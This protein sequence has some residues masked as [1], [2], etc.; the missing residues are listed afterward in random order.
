[1]KRI[2][3]L[4]MA[5]LMLFGTVAALAGCSAPKDNGAQ[6]EI[7]LGNEVCDFDPSD[8]YADSTAEQVM[9]LLY[10]PLFSLDE[11]GKLGLAAA[12]NYEIDYE[13]REIVVELR[14]SYWSDEVRVTAADFIYAWNERLLN[15]TNP[16][17]AAALLYEIENAVSVKSGEGTVSDV[18]ARATGVYEIT[19]TY[20]DGGDPNLLLHNLASVATSPVRQDKASNAPSYWSKMLDTMV[21]NGPFKVKVFDTATS[22]FTLERNRGYHLSL[23]AKNF[24]KRVTPGV[25]Y[26]FFTP[27]GQ[28]ISVTADEIENKTKFFMC[29]ATLADRASAK[30]KAIV[31][32]T[33]SAYT[34]IFNPENPLFAIPEVRQ[35]LIMAIDREA[36]A[37]AITFAKAANGVLPDVCGGSDSDLIS[38]TAKID[39][40]KAL[41]SNVSFAGVSKSFS[42]THANTELEIKIAEMVCEAWKELGFNVT[43]RPV[44]NTKNKVGD[45]EFYDSRIQMLL[46]EASFGNYGYDVLGFDWQFYS[47]DAFTGLSAFSGAMNGCGYDFATGTAR[48]NVAGYSNIE[49]DSLIV[50]AMKLRGEERAEVLAEAE[51]MLVDNAAVCPI[52]FNQSFAIVSKDL[53]NVKLDA[54]GHFILTEAD[55]KNYEKYIGN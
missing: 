16:N 30:D 12:K 35:A 25:L 17:P 28:E 29:E 15:P 36:I 1:M 8:Y 27:F 18:G 53:R 41:L 32:D 6:F 45:S 10:E 9:S 24:A 7:Y 51:K 2:F 23:D 38:T 43:A 20:R 4:I 13:K 50:E 5:V 52:V 3:S 26:N 22:E 21:F 37:E 47:A 40:A 14:E 34:Y 39:E 44:G 49:Y 19:I 48:A 42:I 31:A 55:L 46:K 33:T 11:K 54:F